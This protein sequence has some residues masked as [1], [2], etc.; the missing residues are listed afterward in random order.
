MI[1]RR[2]QLQGLKD[3]NLPSYTSTWHCI[4]TVYAHEGMSAFY[5]GL[6]ACL[7]K[8]IPSV[9]LSWAVYERLKQLWRFAPPP[10][11]VS[12]GG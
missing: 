10:K 8:V 5:K 11:T 3:A 2:M 1:R 4:K 7:L 9:A 12:A 6:T